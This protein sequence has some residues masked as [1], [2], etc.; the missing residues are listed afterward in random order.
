MANSCGDP[1]CTNNDLILDGDGVK[2]YLCSEVYHYECAGVAEGTHRRK[3]A[4][5]RQAWRCAQNCRV[6]EKKEEPPKQFSDEDDSGS[7]ALESIKDPDLKTIFS[8]LM[9]KMSVIE[10]SSKFLSDKYDDLLQKNEVLEKKLKEL[11]KEKDEEIRQL[12]EKYY[13]MEQYERKNNVEIFGL[14][15]SPDED[16][17]DLVTKVVSRYDDKFIRGDIDYAHRL[18]SKNKS[19]P[20]SIIAVLKSRMERNA[21]LDV[22]KKDKKKKKLLQKDILPNST[23]PNNEV[24]ITQNIS[25]FYKNLL[26]KVKESAQLKGYKYVWYNNCQVLVR[27]KDGDK[28]VLRIRDENDLHLLI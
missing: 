17:Y 28:N 12:K 25:G 15:A 22:I 21:L 27:K 20:P 13:E 26:W 16:V 8:F 6:S 4:K 14:E 5:A 24:Y 7:V 3:G 10:K 1:N 19:R 2:C 9:V 18:P 11:K 23:K